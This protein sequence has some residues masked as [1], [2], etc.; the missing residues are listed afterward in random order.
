MNEYHVMDFIF[1]ASLCEGNCPIGGGAI[2]ARGT[3]YSVAMLDVDSWTWPGGLSKNPGM[4][5][6]Q[7][8]ST[9]KFFNLH[10]PQLPLCS[11]TRGGMNSNDAGNLLSKG[12]AP[13]RYSHTVAMNW[14]R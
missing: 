4:A 9:A 11:T 3:V 10:E 2:H 7:L 12:I 8:C 14:H 5:T 1:T 6:H 13:T